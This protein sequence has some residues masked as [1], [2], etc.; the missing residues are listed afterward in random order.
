MLENLLTEE[1]KNQFSYFINRHYTLEHIRNG[2][3]VTFAYPLNYYNNG[4]IGYSIETIK[5][6]LNEDDEIVINRGIEKQTDTEVHYYIE[7]FL[8]NSHI[9]VTDISNNE[10]KSFSLIFFQSNER[11]GYSSGRITVSFNHPTDNRIRFDTRKHT[12]TISNDEDLV[13][14]IKRSGSNYIFT[15]NLLQIDG[16]NKALFYNDTN[17][18]E[19]YLNDNLICSNAYGEITWFTELEMKQTISK[20]TLDK[21]II[22]LKQYNLDIK[23]PDLTPQFIDTQLYLSWD[24]SVNNYQNI[25][26]KILEKIDLD[27]MNLLSED[28]GSQIITQYQS[29]L[30]SDDIKESILTALDVQ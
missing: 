23:I 3:I 20:E 13:V 22:Q 7:D 9:L 29:Y 24:D 8:E 2:I 25:A 14:S 21:D 11:L 6:L 28:V 30:P 16:W 4:F 19:I 18:A 10:L 15:Y 26:M 5:V 17:K 12:V 27:E 1:D